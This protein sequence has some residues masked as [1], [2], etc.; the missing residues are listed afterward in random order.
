MRIVTVSLFFLH[1]VFHGKQGLGLAT[2]HAIMV[3]VVFLSGWKNGWKNVVYLRHDRC[4]WLYSLNIQAR[5]F[6]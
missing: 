2:Y 4:G 6:H 5:G 1:F 3:I